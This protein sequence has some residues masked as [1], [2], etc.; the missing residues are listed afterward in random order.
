MSGSL[1]VIWEGDMT[2]RENRALLLGVGSLLNLSG[3]TELRIQKN[4]Y[5]DI[6][7]IRYDWNRVGS[8]IWRGLADV[9]K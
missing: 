8:L 1:V 2:N 3:R 7:N 9:R 6:R 4:R 5:C